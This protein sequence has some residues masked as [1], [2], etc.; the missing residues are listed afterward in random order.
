MTTIVDVVVVVVVADPFLS[1]FEMGQHLV[2]RTVTSARRLLWM[3]LSPSSFSSS[4]PRWSWFE[5]FRL[6]NRSKV[7]AWDSH[8]D[9]VLTSRDVV[10]VVVAVVV[11]A[12]TVT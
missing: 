3:W 11:V 2:Q 7:V 10:V 1:S 4:L 9:G 8:E 5:S 6:P 12:V